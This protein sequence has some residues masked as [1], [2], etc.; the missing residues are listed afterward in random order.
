M[1]LSMSAQPALSAAC[2]QR[3]KRSGPGSRV[4]TVADPAGT[5][6]ACLADRDSRRSRCED[7]PG[8]RDLEIEWDGDRAV[9]CVGAL[10]WIMRSSVSQ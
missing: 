6:A 2:C 4:T 7:Q 10:A 1:T 3:A 5:G 9:L 8:S